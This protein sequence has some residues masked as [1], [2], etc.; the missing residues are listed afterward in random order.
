MLCARAERFEDERTVR[1]KKDGFTE[2]SNSTVEKINEAHRALQ[3]GMKMKRYCTSG[4]VKPIVLYLDQSKTK[5]VW[6]PS[7]K[8][9]SSTTVY[10]KDILE[11]RVVEKGR[12]VPESSVFTKFEPSIPS[13]EKELT[14]AIVHRDQ[15]AKKYTS[16][17]VGTKTKE[18]YNL[19][20]IVIAYLLKKQRKGAG[21]DPETMRMLDLWMQ[22]DTNNDKRLTTAEVTGLLNKLNV[23]LNSSVLKERFMEADKDASNDLTFDEFREF[24]KSL[25][26]R[27][28]VECW[29]KAFSQK[30]IMSVSDFQKFS[31]ELQREVIEAKE[32]LSIFSRFGGPDPARG[33]GLSQFTNFM[34]SKVNSWWKHTDLERVAHDMDYPLP[35]YFISSSHNTYLTGDQL[36]SFSSTDMYKIVLERGCRCVELDCWD[37]ADGTPEIY[38]GYTRTTKIRFKD[39]CETIHKYAFKTSDYPVI[40]SLENHTSQPQQLVMA[41]QL[42]EAFGDSL[43]R[44]E[45]L[46]D[47]SLPENVKKFTPQAMRKR[48]LLKGKQ[49]H[50][51]HKKR[52]AELSEDDDTDGGTVARRK[53]KQPKAPRHDIATALSELI[54][55]RSTTV[56]DWGDQSLPNEIQSYNES[57]CS[58]YVETD[59]ARFTA[60]NRR[61]LTRIYPSGKRI[62]SDNYDP[63]PAWSVGCQ[64]VALNHQVMDFRLRLALT[65]FDSNGG[66]GY[67]LKPRHLIANSTDF[68]EAPV[69][70]KLSVEVI[71]GYQLPKLA[72][73]VLNPCVSV[74]VNGIKEDT[75]DP[76]YTA[77]VSSN[78]LSPRWDHH[79]T[80]VIHCTA[81]A[82][83]TLRVLNGPE[84]KKVAEASIPVAC[85]NTR[86]GYRSV[87]LRSVADR[88]EYENSCLLCQFTLQ[89][90]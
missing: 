71:S 69:K 73:E 23:R 87:P 82:M 52:S 61:M 32:V 4:R 76:Q 18:D 81:L 16:L 62:G 57:T 12:S 55:I 58:N 30:N 1:A 6:T 53:G 51:H 90:K 41:K 56:M 54:A 7:K 63:F 42:I 60:M 24:Y 20:Q 9:V 19:L 36:S 15:E 88:T 84:R 78:G 72:D 29:F 85:F 34:F 68:K 59:P 47:L 67:L 75:C 45:E 17:N 14:L 89:P 83:L 86:K 64:A 79:F 65:K 2:L 49:A 44:R 74:H 37:G 40:L 38:H 80:F 48:V 27:P 11:V 50:A 8:P 10:V 22:A 35:C 46:G 13:N 33:L 70:Q 25:Q 3:Q 66:C 5:L 77:V 21:R 26:Y 28:E 31:K 39:V 43:L